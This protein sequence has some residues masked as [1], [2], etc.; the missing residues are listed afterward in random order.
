MSDICLLE[1]CSDQIEQLQSNR[2]ITEEHRDDTST[3][4]A[5]KNNPLLQL[6]FTNDR[7]PNPQRTHRT[8]K[9]T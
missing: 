3:S 8:I 2:G 7:H 1:S 4:E 5:Q 6:K 9:V